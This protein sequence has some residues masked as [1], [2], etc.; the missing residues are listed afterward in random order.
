MLAG[1]V[2]VQAAALIKER[3]ELLK[4]LHKFQELWSVGGQEKNRLA[5]TLTATAFPPGLI[6]EQRSVRI[7]MTHEVA[8]V[9]TVDL[10]NQIGDLQRRIEA[11]GVS[12]E[13]EGE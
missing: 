4:K 3:D 5:V 7:T 2:A 1:R 12:V 10:S 11:L 6:S 9:L 8:D 13:G